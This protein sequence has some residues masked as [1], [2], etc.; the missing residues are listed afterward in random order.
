MSTNL[1]K[2]D[3]MP[4]EHPILDEYM[5]Q[6]LKHMQELYDRGINPFGS[7]FER[8]HMIGDVVKNHETLE[9]NQEGEEVVIAGRLMALREHGKASFGDLVDVTGSVQVYFKSNKVGDENYQLLK[10]VDIGDFL[11]AKGKVFKTKRGEL[12]VFVEEFTYLSKSL[13]TPPEKFH[14][15]KDVEVR[16]RQRYVDLLSSPE[17]REIFI[18]RSRVI[19]AIRSLLDS[20][21]FFEVETP[22]MST[23]AG[24]AMARPF[25]THHNALDME[26]YFRIATELYL[27]RCIVGGL[28]K[29]YEIGRIFRNEGID[30][31]HNPEFTMIE[32]YQA[33]AD[34]TDMM[35]IT[36]EIIESACRVIGTHTIKIGENEINLKPPYPRITMEEALKKYAGIEIEKLKD[37][38]YAKQVA[39]KLHLEEFER[40]DD[41]AHMIDKIFGAAVEPHLIQPTFITDYP[42]EL[43][44]LAKKKEGN[45]AITDRFELFVNT[46]ELAN[47]FSELNDPMDQ[48][49][50]F[51]DQVKKK[52][53]LKTEETHPM[54]EDFVMALEYGMP[55][56][57]GLG[58]GID[59]LI[60]LLT[61]KD[62]IREV[63]LFPLLKPKAE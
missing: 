4:E 46:W 24:G 50:R 27:K 52:E 43:S 20:K 7:K 30:S 60:M 14:G 19:S 61:G 38:N 25:K 59:R 62:T 40:E 22:S 23:I 3:T 58:I 32:L 2:R 63:I 26:L 49:E 15:L 57:G 41:L 47:A 33:Y 42:I 21:G 29:V 12:T 17:I 5:E 36:E 37:L 9:E 45:P 55:P 39:K 35:N 56:T 34:Y 54:D 8:T 13:R 6:R 11:G 44:P 48:R 51:L 16:Y 31:K 53:Q 28:E 18:T 10:F 1:E